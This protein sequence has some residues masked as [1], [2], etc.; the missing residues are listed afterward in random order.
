MVALHSHHVKFPTL[1]VT[2]AYLVVLIVVCRLTIRASSV[3]L[4]L[5]TSIS[6]PRNVPC[7]DDDDHQAKNEAEVA[8]PGE[9]DTDG[10]LPCLPA[11]LPGILYDRNETPDAQQSE[12]DGDPAL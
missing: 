3:L 5:T 7:N 9:S 12:Q 6:I 1:F 2:S 10:Q 11:D 8:D 4:G